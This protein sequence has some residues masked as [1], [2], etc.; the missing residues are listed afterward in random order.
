MQYNESYNENLFTYANNIPTH[1]GGTHL[2]GFK[3]A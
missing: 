1:E 3:R 2:M